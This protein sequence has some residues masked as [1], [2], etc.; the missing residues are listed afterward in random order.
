MIRSRKATTN[1]CRLTSS[2]ICIF[3]AGITVDPSVHAD[4][5]LPG[6][7]SIQHRLTFVDSPALRENRL[8]A[9]PVRGFE[10]FQ[11]IRVGQPFSFSTKYGTR[12]YA[13]PSDY[14]PPERFDHGESLEFP[15][16]DPPV[17][18]ITSLSILNSTSKIETRCK[19]VAVNDQSL[20]IEVVEEIE[21]DALGKPT[22]DQF[23]PLAKIAISI[24]GFCGCVVIWLTLRRKNKTQ[25]K[26]PTIARSDS[27]ESDDANDTEKV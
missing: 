22:D 5:I 15:F 16:A 26:D 23:S 6:H 12:I 2:L 3:I 27:M 1:L 24:L 19:L 13:V 18:S 7:K 20:I 14:Q 11:E 8:I 10:G 25:S 4:I 9:A 21:Y 17:N